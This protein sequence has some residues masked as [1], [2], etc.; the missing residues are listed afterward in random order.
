MD[1]QTYVVLKVL[2]LSGHIDERQYSGGVTKAKL[3]ARK[4]E[5]SNVKFDAGIFNRL[6]KEN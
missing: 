6:K 4:D 2:K 5:P 1:N 3:F